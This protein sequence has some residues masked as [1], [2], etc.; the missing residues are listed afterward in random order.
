MEA[1]FLADKAALAEYYGDGFTESALPGN[2][3]IERIPKRDVQTGLDKAT[4]RTG[5]GTYHKTRHGF[6]VLTCLNPEVV[7]ARS[8]FAAELFDVLLAKC[9]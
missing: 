9:R 4:R 3:E 6:D 7:R 2:P 5:K 1:W 8:K